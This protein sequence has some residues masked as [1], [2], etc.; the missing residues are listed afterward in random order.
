MSEHQ[1]TVVEN[2]QNHYVMDV[3]TQRWLGGFA[4]SHYRPWVFPLYTPSGITVLQESPPDHPFH[5]GFFVGQSPVLAGGRSANFWATPPDRVADDPLQ[6]AVGRMSAEGP[7][8]VEP[9]E[10]G[11][12]FELPLVWRDED[13]R[14][15]LDELRRVDFHVGDGATLC[16]MT[17]VK[18][19]AYGPVTLAATKFGSIGMRVEPRLLPDFGGVVIGDAGRRGRSDDLH[20]QP[21]AYV[22]Y[23]NELTGH[24]AYGVLMTPLAGSAPG[25]WF[26]RDYGMAM[27]DATRHDDVVL[28]AG[29]SWT[30][31]LRVAAYDRPLTDERARH[32][33]AQ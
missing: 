9:H 2:K 3:A 18:T 16:D 1:F 17:S 32:W 20:E 31:G 24:G 25:V 15:V 27:Y 19:A 33:I 7:L 4:V 28:D 23:E 26:I 12:R 14:P 21:S 30:V 8:V 22:A 10:H 13:E 11:V 29:G 6:K 5:S